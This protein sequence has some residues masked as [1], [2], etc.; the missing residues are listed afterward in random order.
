MEEL[1]RLLPHPPAQF[2]ATF[3]IA[4]KGAQVQVI[5][6]AEFMD[7]VVPVLGDALS[8]GAMEFAELSVAVQGAQM[9]EDGTAEVLGGVVTV[10]EQGS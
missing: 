10:S 7:Q 5:V 8:L 2:T 4:T 6:S 3:T 9:A 1:V